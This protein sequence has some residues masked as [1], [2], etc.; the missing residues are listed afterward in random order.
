MSEEKAIY[1]LMVTSAK[2]TMTGLMPATPEGVINAR[3]TFEVFPA[4]ASFDVGQLE[5]RGRAMRERFPT[6]EGWEVMKVALM[7]GGER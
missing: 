6:V 4:A 5:A 2:T 1:V 3:C 7:D